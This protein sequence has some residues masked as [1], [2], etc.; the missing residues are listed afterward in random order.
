MTNEEAIKWTKWCISKDKECIQKTI[1]R[2]FPAGEIQET[3]EYYEFVLRSL[4]SISV[5]TDEPLTL[6]QLRE[7]ANKPY[8]HVGLQTDSP[9]PH[10]KILD[11][12]VA[13]CPE[14]YGYGKRWLAYAYPPAHI[15]REAWESCPCCDAA[16]ANSGVVNQA[17]WVKEPEVNKWT[18]F[19]KKLEYCP[20]CGRPLTPEA[21]AELEK[22][23]RG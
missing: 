7:M 21:W 12:F 4:Q 18:L 2:G 22:R 13:R 14:D 6:D 1:E 19:G 5:P 16:K 3:L 15:D 20:I 8:W 9:E 17:L 11:P 23:L 10:W